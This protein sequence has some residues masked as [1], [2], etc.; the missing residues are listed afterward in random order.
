MPKYE[1]TI[2]NKIYE[3]RVIEA[4]NE[5]HAWEVAEKSI[6]EHPH[7]VEEDCEGPEVEGIEKIDE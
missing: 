1:I 4:D 5:E 2:S 7:V 6:N 3:N